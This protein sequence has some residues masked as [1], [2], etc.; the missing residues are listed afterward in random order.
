MA[1]NKFRATANYF[2]RAELASNDGADCSAIADRS[3]SLTGELVD[4]EGFDFRL[5]CLA[6][7]AELGRR[8]S[9][10]GDPS[11]GLGKR[12]FDHGLL[13]LGKRGHLAPRPLGLLGRAGLE[14]RL[15]DDERLAIAQHHGALDH[16]LQ[17]P[18]VPGPVVALKQLKRLLL[19]VA[20]ALTGTSGVALDQIFD[21]DMNVIHA[22]A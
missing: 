7:N 15:I 1:G 13:A 3:A 18:H 22:L 5:E 12:G 19:D 8:S 4:M 14:P 9:R 2:N 21:Q 20:E 17:F 16:V 6:R 11:V 10:A